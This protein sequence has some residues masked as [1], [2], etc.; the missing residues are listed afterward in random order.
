MPEVDE[1]A[2]LP[3]AA[4]YAAWYD[5]ASDASSSRDTLLSVEATP[6][7]EKG[8]RRQ[9]PQQAG[10]NHRAPIV[11][12]FCIVVVLSAFS[13]GHA[14]VN[15]RNAYHGRGLLPLTMDHIFN[16]TLAVEAVQP[17]DWLA[18]AGDGVYSMRT[19][20]HGIDLHDLKSNTTRTLVEGGAVLGRD[21][22]P[23]D[24]RGFS[25][26][27]D[28]RFVLMNVNWVKVRSTPHGRAVLTIQ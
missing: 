10:R 21:G 17:I 15:R 22:Q 20:S 12:V 26:S 13:A 6:D 5:A 28:G 14:R 8:L 19:S 11:V 9:P 2:L 23:L 27:A 1:K 3:P 16:G 18:E 4:L 24:W 25:M 7:E